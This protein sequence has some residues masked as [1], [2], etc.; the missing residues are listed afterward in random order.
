MGLALHSGSG[1][2]R[3]IVEFS[4]DLK[5]W[6][7][8]QSLNE[9]ESLITDALPGMVRQARAGVRKGVWCYTTEDP[10]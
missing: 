2:S 1:V 10:W 9:G 7:T 8:L 6:T 5:A 3:G 4:P